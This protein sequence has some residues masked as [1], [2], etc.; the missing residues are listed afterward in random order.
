MANVLSF[1]MTV[2]SQKAFIL[3]LF[4]TYELNILKLHPQGILCIS[5]SKDFLQ[6]HPGHEFLTHLILT[7][8]Q[9]ITNGLAALCYLKFQ[10]NIHTKL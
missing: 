1:L 5:M 8:L 2:P 3:T 7:W 10:Q 6:S 9:I 4:M